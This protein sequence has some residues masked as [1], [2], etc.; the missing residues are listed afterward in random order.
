MVV[1]YS[2][3]LTAGGIQLLNLVLGSEAV[4]VPAGV[5]SSAIRRPCNKI[6]LNIIG[7]VDVLLTVTINK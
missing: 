3:V 6:P 1:S 4:K 5:V 7:G 2:Y